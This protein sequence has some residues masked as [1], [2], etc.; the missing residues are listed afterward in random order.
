MIHRILYTGFLCLLTSMFLQAQE[1]PAFIELIEETPSGK[2]HIIPDKGPAIADVNSTIRIKLNR[3]AIEKEM[4]LRQGLRSDDKRLEA[5][6]RLNELLKYEAAIFK[7]LK[8]GFGFDPND[9][10]SAGGRGDDQSVMT[11]NTLSD[12][13]LQKIRTDFPDLRKD[14]SRIEIRRAIRKFRNDGKGPYIVFVLDYLE[15]QADSIRN[16]I[17]KDLNLDANKDSSAMIYFRLG[18]FIKNKDG[19]GPI[20][21]ENF[22]DISQEDFPDSKVFFGQ[23]ISAE[24][25]QKLEENYKVSQEMQGDYTFSFGEALSQAK[26]TIVNIFAD[27]AIYD[28]LIVARDTALQILR[29]KSPKTNEHDEAIRILTRMQPS[30]NRIEV[31]YA[32]ASAILNGVMQNVDFQNFNNRNLDQGFEQLEAALSMAKTNL[33]T[34]NLSQKAALARFPADPE[35][36][37]VSRQYEKYIGDVNRDMAGLAALLKDIKDLVYYFRKPWLENEEF[38][39]KVRRF[40]AGDLPPEG[41]IELRYIGRRQPK[42]EILIKA[43]LERGTNRRARSF[44]E[45]EIYRRYVRLERV[46][47]HIRMSGSLILASPM[48]RMANIAAGKIDSSL[49][50]F[51]FAPTYGIFVSWGSRKSVFYNEVVNLGLGLGF[52]SPDFNLDGTPEFGAS[53]MMTAFRDIL[54]TGIGWNFGTDTP[55]WYVGF[56]LPFSVGGLSRGGTSTVLRE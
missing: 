33:D 28:T 19:G 47:A 25:K 3:G 53:I 6:D 43:V 52:S 23:P 7:V 10:T 11:L 40:T 17:L 36:E 49:N 21:V 8:N 30:L 9:P 35:I 55:Y 18:A 13:L 1:N 27:T 16:G 15:R 51:Q 2:E 12:S 34:F 56:N 41:Y 24:E 5:L 38:T 48:N 54:G 29:K 4:F 31:L 37:V 20:H 32:E 39:E 44:Q 26:R 22:D 42:D 45:W 14:L 46:A 50:S